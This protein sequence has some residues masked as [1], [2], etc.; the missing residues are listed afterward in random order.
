MA[1]R[2]AVSEFVRVYNDPEGTQTRGAFQTRAGRYIYL[3][4]YY[5]NAAFEELAGWGA[6]KGQHHLYRHTRSIYNPVRRLVDFY[7]GI[8]YPG[9]LTSDAMPLPD[10][11]PCAIPISEDT[12]PALR[13]AVGQLWQWSNWQIGK[14]L[15][16]RYGAALGDVLLEVIDDTERGKVTLD[17]TWP[18]LVRDLELDMYG[19]V[20]SYTIEYEYEEDDR[21][22]TYTR[23]VDSES[24]RTLRNGQPYAYSEAGAEYANPYGFVPACWVQHTVTGGEHGDPAVR[25]IAAIDELNSLAAHTLDQAHRILETPILISGERIEQL[26]ANS[27]DD[28]TASLDVRSQRQESIKLLRGSAGA[29]VHTLRLDPGEA[30]ANIERLLANIEADHPE[31]SMYNQ[32]RSMGELTGPAADRLLGD[33]QTYVDAARASYDTQSVK[34]FQ[35]AVAIG[36]W[37]AQRG[38]WGPRPLL[39][40]QQQAFAPFDLDSYQAGDLDMEIMPR[41]LVAITERERLEIERL[42]AAVQMETQPQAATVTAGIADRLRVAGSAPANEA[43]P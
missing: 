1:T 43:T 32:L 14:A 27:K 13:A 23:M 4:Q 36:G 28:S 40:R 10:G 30:L 38:D 21:T 35:M 22:Y 5:N 8:V 12:S 41:P 3:W 31:L 11:T 2:A 42:R 26:E 29:G 33:V 17:V 37:R 7:G 24:V 20:K 18:G 16:V 39:N 9:Y 34:A 25:N 19:N 6:Y 15:L